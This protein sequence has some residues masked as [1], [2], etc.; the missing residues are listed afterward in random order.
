MIA[1]QLLILPL[2][3]QG[4]A[5]L[6]AS[7]RTP[8]Y[9]T[10]TSTRWAYGDWWATNKGKCISHQYNTGCTAC[11]ASF[12]SSCWN[13]AS[14]TQHGCGFLG[15]Y[16]HCKN[17]C[18]SRDYGCPN[19]NERNLGCGCGNGED[20][21]YTVPELSPSWSCAVNA[22]DYH[23]ANPDSPDLG[24]LPGAKTC[25]ELKKL[26]W[27]VKDLKIAS[28]GG[29]FAPLWMQSNCARTCGHCNTACALAEDTLSRKTCVEHRKSLGCTG[30]AASYMKRKCAGTCGYCKAGVDCAVLPQPD[31]WPSIRHT[32]DRSTCAEKEAT[33]NLCRYGEG[34][35]NT[36][37]KSHCQGYEANTFACR[38]YKFMFGQ[39]F[40][41]QKASQ[42]ATTCGICGT[43]DPKNCTTGQVY[44]QSECKDGKNG[45]I[46]VRNVKRFE[47]LNLEVPTDFG[48]YCTDGMIDVLRFSEQS[49]DGGSLEMTLE[50]GGESTFT[51][52]T[53][54]AFTNEKGWNLE[55][56]D[57]TMTETTTSTEVL[58]K[59]PEVS[60][61]ASVGVEAFDVGV[62]ASMSS[63]TSC[64]NK[65]TELCKFTNYS[66]APT[67]D[68]NMCKCTETTT[69]TSETFSETHAST[70]GEMEAQS[71]TQENGFEVSETTYYAESSTW[72]CPEFSD[73]VYAQ[74][75]V[76]TT[77][78]IPYWGKCTIVFDEKDSNGHN[79]RKD[80]NI[81]KHEDNKFLAIKSA[82]SSKTYLRMSGKLTDG[83]ECGIQLTP[84]VDNR[85]GVKIRDF[86]TC[87]ASPDIKKLPHCDCMLGR[88]KDCVTALHPA[89]ILTVGDMCQLGNRPT[90]WGY[91]D[92][93]A[94]LSSQPA[95]V[96]IGSCSNAH[97][98]YVGGYYD[99][100]YRTLL[101]G[102]QGPLPPPV[103]TISYDH[104]MVRQFSKARH[105]VGG[106]Y[107]HDG[108]VM[109]DG[110]DNTFW[111]VI[112]M[113]PWHETWTVTFDA[114]NVNT[115][116]TKFKI[117][118]YGDVTHDVLRCYLQSGPQ[119]EGSFVG[120]W[121]LFEVEP[122]HSNWQEFDNTDAH[123][124]RYWRLTIIS[125]G[126]YQPWI[127]ELDFD[128][129]YVPG[130]TRRRLSGEED[131]DDRH[132]P[133]P[134]GMVEAAIEKHVQA[135]K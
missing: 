88:F 33:E 121:T 71:D 114:D 25:A 127:R 77:C 67:S 60:S 101:E 107:V 131:H 44:M 37:M 83:K 124:N 43:C 28:R 129:T 52:T 120:G 91:H 9:Q 49:T 94:C 40:G 63:S 55:E 113:D 117:K 27:C 76:T 90:V 96:Q 84:A 20:C 116:I 54:T 109:L 111:N 68:P 95:W 58:V 57:E 115:V 30:S 106:N 104:D 7:S 39:I 73:C 26:E 80:V 93:S 17:T 72:T 36:W 50:T 123:P 53:Q 98:Y 87:P 66:L 69:T 45:C 12:Y 105:D 62:E 64:M 92:D 118:N 24:G 119:P 18:Y 5:V 42:C 38:N 19:N 51:R 46:D 13:G 85:D 3:L 11:P 10:P 108:S 97:V 102:I 48:R 78:S 75:T 82:K 2:L 86:G 110:D 112:G 61:S 134:G 74:Y 34:A 122:G 1:S 126:G 8:T 81:P 16:L 103:I 133:A 65:N 135:Q 6:G 100:T 56:M 29:E 99:R 47:C 132:M 130:S 79:I 15:C 125:T 21:L 14:G 4:A 89:D 22:V 41:P 23:V 31:A 59:D 128:T 70:K 35:S 32:Q